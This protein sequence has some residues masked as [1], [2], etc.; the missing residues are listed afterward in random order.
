MPANPD[1]LARV[2]VLFYGASCCAGL[3]A[4][5]AGNDTLAR[6]ISVAYSVCSYADFYVHRGVWP[7]HMMCVQFAHHGYR[8]WY[9][10]HVPSTSAGWRA[11]VS[12]LLASALLWAHQARIARSAT[13]HLLGRRVRAA[14]YYASVLA[15]VEASR[16]QGWYIS[17]FFDVLLAA[18]LH[19]FPV[20]PARDVRTGRSII[21][22][23]EQ[24]GHHEGH[25][26]RPPLLQVP[27]HRADPPST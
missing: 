22:G 11:T 9:V 3:V 15:R 16:T 8:L 7:S 1:Q 19:M 21:L 27:H 14:T 18:Y 24:H 20:F 12:F 23:Q 2:L 6:H 5:A 25:P 17:M 4:V 13:G 10:L 26:H